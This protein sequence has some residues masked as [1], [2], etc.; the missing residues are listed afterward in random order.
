MRNLII[1]FQFIVLLPFYN[2]TENVHK[3]NFTIFVTV[4]SALCTPEQYIYLYY[5]RHNECN[6]EDSTQISVDCRTVCL[7]GYVPEQECVSLLFEKQGPGCVNMIATPGDTIFIHIG[8]EDMMNTVC[9][10]VIGSSATNEEAIYFNQRSSLILERFSLLEQIQVCQSDSIQAQLIKKCENIEKEMRENEI[11]SLKNTQHPYIAWVRATTLSINSY[12]TDS[13][14]KLK[15]ETISRFPNYAKMERLYLNRKQMPSS[16]EK[17]LK[18]QERI[19]Q[20]KRKKRELN[21]R[22]KSILPPMNKDISKENLQIDGRYALWDLQASDTNDIPV[23]LPLSTGKYVL[24]DFWASW[25]MPCMHNLLFLKQIHKQYK[26][27][28]T[29]YTISLDKDKKKWKSFIQKLG[30][31][32]LNNFS[33]LDNFDYLYPN[34]ER[35]RIETIPANYL[36]SPN[37]EILFIDITQKQLIQTLNNIL[38]QQK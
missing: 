13:V 16:S 5:F 38:S 2:R 8:E 27:Y 23:V 30:L 14:R 28:L 29:I 17:S 18:N 32:E 26:N 11:Q 10:N 36:L 21:N 34:I 35:L 37:G 15:D 9:K 25:C 12:G 7:Q 20:I 1:I 31:N 3:N 22:E 6:I 19:R 4:D 24:I 33:A